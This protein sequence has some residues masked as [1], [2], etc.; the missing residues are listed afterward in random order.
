MICSISISN[1]EW[2][3]KKA[4]EDAKRK[5]QLAEKREKELLEKANR[6]KKNE[7][8]FNNWCRKAQ[9]RPR[10]APSSYGYTEGKLTGIPS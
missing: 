8:A 10:T 9:S 1:K 3:Q 4:E 7:E 5:Q 6:Q 2:V